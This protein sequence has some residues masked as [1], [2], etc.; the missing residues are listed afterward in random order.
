MSEDS[1]EKYDQIAKAILSELNRTAIIIRK[2]YVD[3]LEAEVIAL[4]QKIESMEIERLKNMEENLRNTTSVLKAIQ[5]ER[6][7]ALHAL[8]RE[9]QQTKEL[10][11]CLDAMSLRLGGEVGNDLRHL[12]TVECGSYLHDGKI[13][14]ILWT[15]SITTQPP[16]VWVAHVKNANLSVS[17]NPSNP[18]VIYLAFVNWT[19]EMDRRMMS[20]CMSKSYLT[21]EH[22]MW[23]AVIEYIEKSIWSK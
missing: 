2:D 16:E 11:Q 4:K 15:K 9:K 23:A 19:V 13:T 21:I 7:E 20:S 3:D 5:A 6:D 14:P 10:K 18:H 1:L 22:A 17:Y 12:D 8:R